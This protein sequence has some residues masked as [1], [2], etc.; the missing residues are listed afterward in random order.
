M[1]NIPEVKHCA[2]D[3]LSR[4]PISEPVKL[5]LPDDVATVAPESADLSI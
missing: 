4:H 5:L 2:A 3:C 1:M